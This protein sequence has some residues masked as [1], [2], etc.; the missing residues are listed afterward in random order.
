MRSVKCEDAKGARIERT[1]GQV[2]QVQGH[3]G[4][5]DERTQ[6][7]QGQVQGLLGYKDIRVQGLQ[8]CQGCEGIVRC[9]RVQGMQGHKD[10]RGSRLLC[11]DKD[12]CK[13]CKGCVG[14]CKEH[15][16][17]E[18][19]IHRFTTPSTFKEWQKAF[20]NPCHG[21]QILGHKA[22]PTTKV[23]LASHQ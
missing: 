18:G 8:R 9:A 22:K 20:I 2:Q 4:A 6:G 11:K 10:P 13:G 16:G 14:R 21:S 3:K 1:Q 12:R 5:R 23:T 15:E 17:C 19:S 7:M